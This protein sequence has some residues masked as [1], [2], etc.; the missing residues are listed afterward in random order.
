MAAAFTINPSVKVC[1]LDT[2]IDAL[3]LS[4]GTGGANRNNVLHII[5]IKGSSTASLQSAPSVVNLTTGAGHGSA[6]TITWDEVGDSLT[7][8][9]D[10][11]SKKWNII[12]YYGVGF[13]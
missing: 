6:T 1:F 13:S 12:S 11:Q 7:L 5:M 4:L 3:T 8:M 2:S 9:W 10:V